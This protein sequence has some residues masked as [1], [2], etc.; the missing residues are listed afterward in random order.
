MLVEEE[1]ARETPSNGTNTWKGNYQNG[2]KKD[3]DSISK[4]VHAPDC[5]IEY[6]PITKH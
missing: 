1:L 3:N 6:I 4:E 5:N 2:D